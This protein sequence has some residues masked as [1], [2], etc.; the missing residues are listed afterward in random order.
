LRDEAL[1]NETVVLFG[2]D[3]SAEQAV[4]LL[5]RLASQIGKGGLYTGQSK[6]RSTNL[7][8]KGEPDLIVSVS[9]WA[10]NITYEDYLS[11]AFDRPVR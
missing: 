8:E 1:K 5:R 10:S 4:N 11:A 3:V 9:Q 7:R 6:T 2:P